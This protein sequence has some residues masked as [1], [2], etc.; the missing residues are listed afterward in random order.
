VR[1]ARQGQS[2]IYS[3]NRSR[4]TGKP[5]SL[6]N[7]RALLSF[8]PFLLWDGG[9]VGF[10]IWLRIS[11]GCLFRKSAQAA[12][13]LF[14]FMLALQNLPAQ[15]H[16][17][18][19]GPDGGDARAFA[20]VPG[21]P[22]HLYLGTTS[23]WIYESVDGG[24]SWQRLS[25]LN[26]EDNL[27][28]DHI[29]VDPAH[30]STVYVGAWKLDQLGGGLWVSHDGAR[31]WKAI[32]GLRG[33]SIRALAQAHSDPRLLFAGTLDGVFRSSDAGATWALISPPGSRE[34]HEVESLAI[35]PV[36]PRI[37]YAGTWHLPRKTTDGGRS[38][39]SIKQ[40][41]IEDSDMF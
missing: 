1:K 34:I 11:L 3:C 18:V 2:G 9:I 29:L 8:M 20:S 40:G 24:A 22:N 17:N 30:P 10:M 37:V 16:W 27:I 39:N 25:K 26:S 33:Q 6:F 12:L 32:E 31:S 36:D 5:V 28:L 15:A 14:F 38:W 35:D 13:A 23:S 4:L 41:L 7:F 19:V 21:E